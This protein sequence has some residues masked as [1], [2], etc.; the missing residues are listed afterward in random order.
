MVKKLQK[1]VCTILDYRGFYIV[2][3]LFYHYVFLAITPPK[4]V[5][6]IEIFIYYQNGYNSNFIKI[7]NYF[8][9]KY[10]TLKFSVFYRCLIKHVDF[11][12]YGVKKSQ[13]H[14][15]HKIFFI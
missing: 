11:I 10:G 4:I 7:S 12:F 15:L 13:K 3:F 14:N 6:F 8:W 1:S 9:A 5:K 2:I